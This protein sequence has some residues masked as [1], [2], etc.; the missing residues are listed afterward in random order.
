MLGK[1]PR[2]LMGNAVAP[3]RDFFMNGPKFEVIESGKV[4]LTRESKHTQIVKKLEEYNVTEFQLKQVSDLLR[5]VPAYYNMLSGLNKQS[6][7][8]SKSSKT[9]NIKK[10]DRMKD[11]T[12]TSPSTVQFDKPNY[13]K[14]LNDPKDGEHLLQIIPI[15][16]DGNCFYSCIAMALNLYNY[17]NSTSQYAFNTT[18]H[19][20]GTPHT[21]SETKFTQEIIRWAVVNEYQNNPGLLAVRILYSRLYIDGSPADLE[22]IM[23]EK[24]SLKKLAEANPL[25]T[26][27][28]HEFEI[29][30]NALMAAENNAGYNGQ[31]KDQI[32][33][34][35]Q[36]EQYINADD[37]TKSAL[38]DSLI[39]TFYNENVGAQS[40]FLLKTPGRAPGNDDNIFT[41]PKSEEDAYN[42]LS[43]S[44]HWST[45]IDRLM[46]QNIFSIK[47]MVLSTYEDTL[48]KIGALNVPGNLLM[49]RS[50]IIIRDGS[51]IA[52]RTATNATPAEV[53]SINKIDKTIFLYFSGDSHYD[54]IVF[55][56]GTRSDVEKHT[57]KMAAENMRE[58]ENKGKQIVSTVTRKRRGGGISRDRRQT[59]RHT[60]GVEVTM[61][62]GGGGYKDAIF[63]ISPSNNIPPTAESIDENNILNGLRTA[64]NNIIFDVNARIPTYMLMFM[65]QQYNK[66][67]GGDAE[68]IYKDGVHILVDEVES[69]QTVL[70]NATDNYYKFRLFY[71]EFLTIDTLINAMAIP[72]TQHM[73]NVNMDK[74]PKILHNF[75]IAYSG[76]F[77]RQ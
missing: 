60:R 23:E 36:T 30:L 27:H 75:L 31:I 40:L 10:G 13:K 18:D 17:H 6:L 65:Y 25:V 49:R 41:Y 20:T 63:T 59:R 51:E 52:L 22:T 38:I 58:E 46:V 5:T 28:I 71:T 35:K 55:G 8:I 32:E 15:A 7:E 33:V 1:N 4:V 24:E 29:E 44:N 68:T 50:G 12:K 53:D 62:G 57:R 16:T 43:S 45:D 42:I 34:F 61:T 37:P 66:T 77:H 70:E 2:N 74:M 76:V 14:S 3:M 73:E 54:L 64:V 48:Y 19:A 39:D 47:P 9:F 69:S 72:D 11:D 21:T 67:R 56:V 26:K